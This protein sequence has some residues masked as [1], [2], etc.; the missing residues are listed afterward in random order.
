MRWSSIL[1]LATLACSSR[2][3]PPAPEVSPPEPPAPVAPPSPPPE[4]VP[5]PRPASLIR[6]L[7]SG[8]RAEPSTIRLVNRTGD[9]IDFET[10]WGQ[11]AFFGASTPSGDLGPLTLDASDHVCDCVCTAAAGAGCPECER[12]RDARMTLGPRGTRELA[13]NGRLRR[14]GTSASQGRCLEVFDPEPGPLLVGACTA[15]GKSCAFAE[16]RLPSASPIELSFS[17]SPLRAAS[18][19]LEPALAE[20]AY[21]IA[22]F[23][24]D[25][26]AVVPDRRQSCRMEASRCVMP[27]AIELARAGERRQQCATFL[28]PRR[29]G[30]EVETFLPLPAGTD[31]GESY[32]VFLDPNTLRVTRVRYEQ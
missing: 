28:V 25:Q 10:T 20:R 9:P 22:T 26:A 12:P 15:D 32:S 14:V 5:A 13:W 3:A 19:P 1:T 2:T 6:P 11:M 7:P 31:G 30:L 16:A 8:G 23:T 29:E 27:E 17:A 21:R 24:M 18:C 4:P